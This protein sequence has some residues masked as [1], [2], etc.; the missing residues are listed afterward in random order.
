VCCGGKQRKPLENE[1]IHEWGKE[2]RGGIV[3][4]MKK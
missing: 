3:L 1:I 4:N 2:A